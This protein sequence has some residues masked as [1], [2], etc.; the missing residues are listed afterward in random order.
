M[1]GPVLLL[2]LLLPA[3]RPDAPFD[4]TGW[5]TYGGD[6]G[7]H[8]YSTLDQITPAN[9]HRLEVAWTYHTGDARADDRSQIQCN[10]LIVDGTLYGTSPGL[11]LFA[12]DAA[13]GTE[14][15]VFDPFEGEDDGPGPLGVNRGVVYWADGP[16]RRILF[17]AG[18]WL[19]AIDA[20][21]GRPVPSFGTG[22]RV[23]LKEGLGRNADDLFVIANTPGALYRDLLILGSRVSENADAAPG[24]LR[25]Y[26]VRTGALVWRFHTIPQ[27]GEFG[28]D[29]WP[30][31][32]YTYIGGANAW[33][34]MTVDPGRGWV[35]VPTGSAAFDFWGG[36]R[37]GQNLF[38]NTLLALDAA[39]GRRIWHIQIVRHDLWDRDLPAPPNLVTVTHGG[40]RIDA[41]AQI[42]KSGHVFL[43]DRETGEPL[44][45][46]EEI[47][48]PP[49]DLRGEAV[50][51]T[52]ILPTKPPPFARQVFTEDLI[53][54]R[55]PE[56][57]AA[58]RSRWAQVRSGGPF[59]PP[60]TQGTVIFPGFDGGGEWGG[61]AFDP[62]TG[63]LYVNSNE[64]P[65]ILTMVDLAPT[66]D[67]RP[68]G[69]RLYAAN[70]AV[71][72]G[73]D[74]AGDTA[75]VIPSLRDLG[76]R[77]QPSDVAQIL[78]RGQ[79]VMPAF[80]HLTPAETEALI[81]FLFDPE[82]AHA[83]P[84]DPPEAPALTDPRAVPYSHTG[85][86]R[87][88]DP[89]GYPAVKPPWG[90]LN[91]IDLNRGT[92]VWQVPLGEFEELTAQGLPKT[93]TENYGGPIV[94][95]GGLI[96]IG[97]SK[98]EYFRAF[99]KTTG[100]ELWKVKLPAG[101]YATPATYALDGKQYVVIA[102]G[103]GK[104]GTPSGDAYVAFALPD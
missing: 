78:Q 59:T 52:Q 41:V 83:P 28:Y 20:T 69:A 97:A 42:T 14:R 94:T 40:R 43:L 104:M 26:D 85:Y 90:T 99:D 17:T 48:V 7:S 47:P 10:P 82:A 79:G 22:G 56:A 93:G 33:A 80:G 51:P 24:H 30:E 74:R 35:F 44:F 19:Y 84:A 15:W 6:A 39:T 81:A 38:A 64:M 9:V 73:A 31:D 75:G 98:D 36:N 102:A 3:C 54:D 103:G 49:S 77:L 63:W 27:P 100:E 8:Q 5:T 29:T 86:N 72:H 34:G 88:L 66:E 1:R 62:E 25:A 23:S 57:H 37:K 50:W 76:D 60:S 89:D 53:T 96:F 91:A 32:A 70:C 67:S 18:S 68:P 95:A 45:P 2:L 12:L 46:V 4:L 92:L 87:F 61:A 11:K 16:D 65:W 13:T 55:T 58:V 71:C 21:T 101:G